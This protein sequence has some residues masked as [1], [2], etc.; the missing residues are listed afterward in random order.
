M[1]FAAGNHVQYVDFGP[2]GWHRIRWQDDI[3]AT[4]HAAVVRVCRD[5]LNEVSLSCIETVGI[6][7]TDDFL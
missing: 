5:G 7:R 6:V 3:L 4:A 1:K 2:M